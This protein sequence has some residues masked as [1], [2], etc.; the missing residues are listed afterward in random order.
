MVFEDS[1]GVNTW[2]T[3]AGKKNKGKK[4]LEDSWIYKQN[5]FQISNRK[6]MESII[7]KKKDG[8]KG[9]GWTLWYSVVWI[10]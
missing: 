5:S 7:I 6:K 3:F 8:E 9:R 4:G 2:T 1:E 10:L